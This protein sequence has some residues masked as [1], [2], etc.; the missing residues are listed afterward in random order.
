MQLT[1]Q[2]FLPTA[3]AQDLPLVEGGARGLTFADA[4]ALTASLVPEGEPAELYAL[5]LLQAAQRLLLQRY[6]EAHPEAFAG[7]ETYLRAALGEAAINEIAAGFARTYGPAQGETLWESLLLLW[8]AHQNPAAEAFCALCPLAPLGEAFPQAMQ[9]AAAYFASQ[10]PLPPENLPVPEALL[11]PIHRA[12][13]SLTAQL[14]Y[15]LDAWRAALEEALPDLLRGLDYAREAQR[16]TPAAA[17]PPPNDADFTA[18]PQGADAAEAYSPDRAWMPRLVLMAKHTYVWLAQLSRRFGRPI[19]RLDQIPDEALAELAEWGINGLWLIGVWERSPASQKIKHL[20]GNPDA[21]ASAYSVYDYQIAQDLGGE[22]ALEILKARA[23]HFG[24]RL[25]ADMVPNHMGLDS[26]W[27]IEHPDWFIQTDHPPFPNYRF[28][29][30]NLSSHP[31]VEIRIEDGYYTQTDAAVVFEMRDHR[32]GRTRY[33]YHGNDGTAIPWNDTAQLNHLLPEVREA[34][35]E[36]ILAVARR[37]PVIRFDAAMTLTRQHYQRLWFPA[38]GEGGAIPSRSAFGMSRAEFLRHMPREFWR[39]VV[40]RV[41]AEAPDTLLLAEAFWLLEGYFVRTLGMHRVYNS[42]F[43][44]MLRD[45]R[46]A[47]YHKLVQ[48]TLLFDPRILQRYVNFMTTPDEDPAVV[49]F[50]KGDKYFGVATLMAT[51]PG[52]PMFGHGQIE[53]LQERYGHEFRAP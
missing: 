14:A 32:D 38:P 18:I 51:L 13:H 22:E 11:A 28:T 26:R 27:V 46:N 15:V 2:I 6:R 17:P 23:A 49:Q 1:P 16:R 25:G 9:D 53:G 42:A 12:P 10:P 41:A 7:L 34:L 44:H 37:F 36:T 20:T 31:T 39:E 19:Q 4:Q 52:L 3:L 5:A 35:I 50:G 47:A 40:D 24:I 43:M 45:E 48:E 29:G 30:P 21:L 8:I 33:I